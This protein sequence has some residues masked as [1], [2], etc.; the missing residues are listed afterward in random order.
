MYS[1]DQN[2]V[3]RPLAPETSR[4]NCRQDYPDFF[5]LN[6]AVFVAVAK[7]LQSSGTFLAEETIGFEMP[8]ER[9]LDIDTEAD[10]RRFEQSRFWQK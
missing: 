6:G 3:L 7:W 8:E 2:F 10:I 1:A 5:L 4:Y 9:S